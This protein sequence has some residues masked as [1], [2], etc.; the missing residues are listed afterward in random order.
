MREVKV[1]QVYRHFKGKEYIVLNI[2]YDSETNNDLEPHKLVV[3]QALY[4]DNLIWVR[5][6]ENI[7]RVCCK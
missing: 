4:G 7:F 3:Y 5:D 6:Y 2:A 1:G